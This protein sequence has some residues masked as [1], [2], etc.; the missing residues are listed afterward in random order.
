MDLTKLE[1]VREMNAM[2]KGY[3]NYYIVE[4]P[5]KMGA[6]YQLITKCFKVD[7]IISIQYNRKIS[8]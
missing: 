3:K 5:N 2:S 1:E 4:V 7:D 6:M 8:K